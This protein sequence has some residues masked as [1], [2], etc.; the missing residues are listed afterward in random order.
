MAKTQLTGH[1]FLDHGITGADLASK[2]G[3]YDESFQYVVGDSV[4]WMKTIFECVSY[5]SVSESGDLSR[6]PD[7]SSDW[8]EVASD[9]DT[10]M[11]GVYPSSNQ[12][13]TTTRTTVLFDLEN[14]QSQYAECSLG[15]V[16]ILKDIT[17]FISVSIPKICF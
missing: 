3:V 14:L 9:N 5:V 16:T 17:A 10:L 15:E 8:V 6:S 12:S 7:V 2:I 13:F 4:F 11:Y 1:Q